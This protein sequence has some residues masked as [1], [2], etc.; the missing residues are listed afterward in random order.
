[1]AEDDK[2]WRR[3]PEADRL[4]WHVIEKWHKHLEG[5]SIV[6]LGRPKAAKKD[7]KTVFASLSLAT[8][9]DR[10]L[11]DHEC[12]YILTIGLD[13]WATLTPKQQLA[14]I[15]HEMCHGLG[16]DPEKGTWL[17]V[18]HDV[19]EFAVIVQR[20]GWWRPDLERFR[21]ATRDVEAP[22]MTIEEAMENLRPKPGSGI[23][24]VTIR[25]GE[26]SVT[27]R[28]EDAPGEPEKS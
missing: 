5:A 2:E 20:H 6:A 27:L 23:E 10:A 1:M 17:L 3:M 9:K 25:S 4:V 8:P 22:Q 24:S 14:C 16:Y 26:H 7:G 28:A 19:E 11:L 12:D 15:D 18:G 21:E 13:A